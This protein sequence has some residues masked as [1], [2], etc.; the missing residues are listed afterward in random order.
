[1]RGLFFSS[2]ASGKALRELT[3]NKETI[4]GMDRR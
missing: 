4:V 3:V 1:M 2:S